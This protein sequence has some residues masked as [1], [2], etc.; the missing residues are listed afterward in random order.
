M[1]KASIKCGGLPTVEAVPARSPWLWTLLLLVA[2]VAVLWALPST[3]T[4]CADVWGHV[5]SLGGSVLSLLPQKLQPMVAKGASVFLSPW[6]YLLMAV[7]F[8]AEKVIPADRQ[9]GVFSVGM[10]QDFVGWFVI[11]GVVRVVLV[12]ALV[13]G[14]YW[15][16]NRFLS[17][18]RIDAVSA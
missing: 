18:L 14:L 7:V 17:G 4:L 1:D 6:L 2:G 5:E 3:R 9:Q 15:F 12:G 10:V 8:L 16:C 11:G 13:A